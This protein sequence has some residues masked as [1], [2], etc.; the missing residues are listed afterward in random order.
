MALVKLLKLLPV[1]LRWHLTLRLLLLRM[2]WRG[3]MRVR[4][5]ALMLMLMIGL[6]LGCMLGL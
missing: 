5:G 1:L 4:V 2:W 3:R 6:C